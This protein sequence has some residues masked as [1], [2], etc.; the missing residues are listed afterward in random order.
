MKWVWAI[1]EVESGH[2]TLVGGKAAALS[3]LARNGLVVPRTLCVPAAVYQYFLEATGLEE[4]ILT[5][6]N[7]KPFDRMRWEDPF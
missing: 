7:R 4:R 2:G 6:L 1:D 3:R 5:E